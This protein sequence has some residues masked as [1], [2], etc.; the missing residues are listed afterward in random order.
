MGLGEGEVLL[1]TPIQSAFA[2][3]L[4]AAGRF[5]DE[6]KTVEARAA[7]AQVQFS[8]W[9]SGYADLVRIRILMTLDGPM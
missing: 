9:L 6:G 1:V 2:T 7:L 3:A 4:G 8:T 5:A